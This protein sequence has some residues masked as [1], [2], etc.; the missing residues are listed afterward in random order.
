VAAI[1]YFEGSYQVSFAVLLVPA[2][3]ALS[4][5]ARTRFLYPRP[6][7]FEEE[8]A[9]LQ[10]KGFPKVFWLYFVAVALIAAGFVDF[11][12][13]AFHFK[14][15]V[16]VSDDWIPI[17]YA[18]A[19]GVDAL[20]A[21]LFGRLFDRVGVPI[22]VASTIVSLFCVPLVFLGNFYFA[23]LGI[24]LWGVGMG[25]Q[26]SIMRAAIAG[27]VSVDRRGSAY[28]IFNTGYGIF[29]FL[30]STLM[31]FL[32]DV[33]VPALVI[34]SVVAQLAS[35]PIFLLIRKRYLNVPS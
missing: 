8:K 3:L 10:S 9:K 13:I 6:R 14:E 1:L 25:A 11:S 32:Y 15:A 19:M 27:M 2:I 4:V 22:L 16:V 5:L 24:V 7:A 31:G 21:L 20:A 29:W 17:F 18:V 28:G 35:V 12:M 23:L 33:S 30:G 34:F 26:E